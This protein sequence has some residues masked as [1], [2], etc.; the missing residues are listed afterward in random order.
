MSKVVL[1]LIECTKSD[2]TKKA[3]DDYSKLLGIKNVIDSQRFQDLVV[4]TPV[5]GGSPVR[6][7]FISIEE[8][9]EAVKND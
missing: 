9:C 7:D 6:K 2:S 5:I 8:M 1:K 3:T 4:D